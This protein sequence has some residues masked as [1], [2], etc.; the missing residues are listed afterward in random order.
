[1]PDQ[2]RRSSSYLSKMSN[3]DL[4][5]VSDALSTIS[6]SLF[7]D[8]VHAQH[9]LVCMREILSTGQSSL[10]DISL[11][12]LLGLVYSTAYNIDAKLTDN[13]DDKSFIDFRARDQSF[14]SNSA[15]LLDSSESLADML[16]QQKSGAIGL[17]GRDLRRLDFDSHP[18]EEPSVRIRRHAVLFS[19]DPIRAIIMSTRII[20]IVPPGGMDQILEI[21]ENYMRGTRRIY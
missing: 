5:V 16:I 6:P 4:Q 9:K 7:A 21:V 11:R 8:D 3:S 10:I 18:E 20:I 15:I 13:L 12:H 1:M 14:K 17:L 2:D 19:V